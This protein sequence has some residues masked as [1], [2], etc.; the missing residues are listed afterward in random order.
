MGKKR[1]LAYPIKEG[2]VSTSKG[3]EVIWRDYQWNTGEIERSWLVDPSS[4]SGSE[5]TV[6]PSPLKRNGFPP[7]SPTNR[8]GS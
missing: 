5:V 2:L 8:N 4:I 7:S 3:R 6:R 1:L